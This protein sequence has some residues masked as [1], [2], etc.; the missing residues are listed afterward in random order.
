MSIAELSEQ[1]QIRR[2]SLAQLRELGIDPYPAARYEVTA[3]AAQIAA[4]YSPEKQ[5]FSD[6][7]IAG[8]ILSRR[9]M[10]SASFFELQDHTG[11]I[12]VYIKR[13]EVC[14]DDPEATLYNKVF[15]KLLDIG[16]IVGVRGLAFVTKTGELSVHCKEL[17]LLSKSLRPLP[18][19]AAPAASASSGW[20]SGTGFAIGNTHAPAFMLATISRVTTPGALTPMNTSAPRIASAS[21]PVMRRGFVRRLISSCAGFS[22]SMPSQR[23]PNRSTIIR[24]FT[25]RF[26]RCLPM[27]TPA[28][29]APLMTTFAVSIVL[30]T[31]FSALSIAAATTTAVPC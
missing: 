5:N 1:E 26:I 30:P 19:T 10:G 22:P 14:G 8:R 11:K 12:Q 2:N 16:D 13:D 6:I 17:K 3:T 21:V 31:T 15:K 7:S 20:I 29:P 24:S 27:A 23:M 4:E 28:L 9:I 18:T 25:P